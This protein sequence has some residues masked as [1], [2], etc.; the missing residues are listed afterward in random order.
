VTKP[1]A[2]KSTVSTKVY[3]YL[4]SAPKAWKPYATSLAKGS[5]TKQI[6]GTDISKRVE[7]AQ[8]VNGGFSGQVSKGTRPKHVAGKQSYKRV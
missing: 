5:N 4:K 7:K 8:A 3:D 2:H 1:R 6:A